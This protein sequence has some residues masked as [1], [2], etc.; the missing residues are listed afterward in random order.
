MAFIRVPAAGA[1][2]RLEMGLDEPQ[3]GAE[4]SANEPVQD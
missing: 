3:G 1:A 4:R 2:A